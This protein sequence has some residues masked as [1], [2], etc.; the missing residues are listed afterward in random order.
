M[1]PFSVFTSQGSISGGNTAGSPNRIVASDGSDNVP[2]T[3]FS[4]SN[5]GY[6][7]TGTLAGGGAGRINFPNTYSGAHTLTLLESLTTE[8]TTSAGYTVTLPAVSGAQGQEYTLINIG[9]NTLTVQG[10]GS[11]NIQ[12]S[13]G[14]N[15]NTQTIAA[16][17]S[18]TLRC[19]KN[20]AGTYQWFMK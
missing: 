10:N 19:V 7:Q 12:L 1:Q 13:G 8:D 17:T 15:A 6:L 9:S 11:D 14:S 2:A 4:V 16:G 3:S 5:A 18:A 20:H